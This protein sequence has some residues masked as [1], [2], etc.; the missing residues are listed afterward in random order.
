MPIKKLKK[1]P[2]KHKIKNITKPFFTEKAP[3]AKGRSFLCG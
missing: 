3:D 1:K 2:N